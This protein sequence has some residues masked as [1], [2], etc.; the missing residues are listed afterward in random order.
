MLPPQSH[1]KK[2]NIKKRQLPQKS[3][4]EG[5]AEVLSDSSYDTDLAASSESDDAW[6]NSE[7]EFDPDGEIV[8]EEDEYDPSMFSYD[9]NDPYIDV[10]MVFPYVD[11]CKLAVT[12]HAILHDHAFNI[13]KKDTTRSRAIC[14]RANHGCK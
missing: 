11:Q 4:S 5:D 10:N 3:A 12:H 1:P 8:D 6:S 7:T 13:V 2:D 9:A 14:K